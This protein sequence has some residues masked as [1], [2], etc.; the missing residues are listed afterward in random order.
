MRLLISLFL[1]P[2]WAFAQMPESEVWLFQLK[3]LK[4]SAEPQVVSGNNITGRAGYDNQPCFTPDGKKIIYS[5]ARDNRN[6]LFVFHTGKK[7][8]TPLRLT[9]ESE[10]S[11]TVW[12]SYL[13]SVVVEK[14]SS[15]TIHQMAVE[16]GTTA[17]VLAPDSVGYYQWLNNDTLLYYKL[18]TPHS[19]W[20]YVVSQQREWCLAT[21]PIRTFR[22][23]SRTQFIYGI[24][25]S[26]A[27]VFLEY[28][29]LLHKAKIITR[30]E[31]AG[32]DFAVHPTLGIVRAE[33]SRLLYYIAD[34]GIWKEWCNLAGFGVKKIS[35]ITFSNNG[36]Q[37]AISDLQ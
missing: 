28:D 32:E 11:P 1:F 26:N 27:V 37:L 23:T 9:P 5:S 6:D 8:T 30:C 17:L 21:R 31:G 4:G 20:A 15:Q 14:D 22:A 2:L 18:T 16:T 34:K 24:N 25:D 19:L 10:F 12:N 33:G 36:K 3:P 7:T 13:Y 35:R 29:F